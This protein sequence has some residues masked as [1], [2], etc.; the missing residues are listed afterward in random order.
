MARRETINAIV[1]LFQKLGGNV[2]DVLGTR[3]NISFLGKGK[4]SELMVDMDINTEALGV[5]PQ[6]KA[7]EELKSSVGYAVG[8]KLN[9]IQANKLLSNMQ[10]MDTIYNPA[11]AP[12]NITDLATGT[13]NLDKE[14]L[15]SLRSNLSDDQAR[16]L[17]I[18]VPKNIDDLPPPGS[19]GGPDD[20]AAPVQ[21]AD[22][23]FKNMAEAQ[24]VKVED[25][26]LPTGKGLEAIKNVQ[27]NNLIVDDLVDTIYLNAGVTKNAQP[28][29]RAN[30]RDFLNR[31]KDLEDPEFPGGPTLSS[32]MEPDDFRFMTEGGGGGMGDPL[33]LVQKY[34]G[35]KVATAIAKLENPNDIQK[36]AERLV[37]VK[38]GR[39]RS[40]TDRMF[41]PQTVNPEDFEF[42]D[43]GRVPYMAGM[44]VRGGK[45]GYQALRKYGIE[46]KDISRLFSSLGAD[47]SLVGKE[48]T[49]Y[50][51]QLHK[52][53]RNPD[54]YPEFIKDIQIRLGLDPIGFKSGGLAKILEV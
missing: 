46:G 37:R 8:N 24:G 29:A 6:S 7:V 19:R 21:S 41:D 52:V 16:S 20:I 40:V 3:S 36:F 14:G 49:A 54:D 43:G 17:G 27:N 15:M 4:S 50:F 30:A 48:K 34:F 38:D 51:Q 2:S 31:V 11:P 42:A 47:K 28:T 1:Q 18:N 12:S 5:L 13:R 39:G 9:D 32:V 45:I 22:E 10:K 53:L 26:I 35:P 25:T 23:V 44:L 33:L